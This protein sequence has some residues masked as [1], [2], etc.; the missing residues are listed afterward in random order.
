[1][2]AWRR[3]GYYNKSTALE[4]AG[5][6]VDDPGEEVAAKVMANGMDFVQLFVVENLNHLHGHLLAFVV[7][8]RGGFVGATIAEEVGDEDTI[9]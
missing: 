4:S 5:G 9:A 1:M 3:V 8:G 7:G 6:V 2:L